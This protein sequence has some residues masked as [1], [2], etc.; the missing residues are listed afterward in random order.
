MLRE[1]LESLARLEGIIMLGIVEPDYP[2]D[3][4]RLRNWLERG[5]NADMHFLTRYLDLR[6][7]PVRLLPNAKS[8][9]VFALPYNAFDGIGPSVAGY[10][11]YPDYHQ[12]FRK[13][14]ERLWTRFSLEPFRVLVDSAPILERALAKKTARGFVGKN[15]CFIHP[16]Y[17]SFFLLGEILT[18]RKLPFDSPGPPTG[19]LRTESGGCGPCTACQVSC[20]TGALNHDFEMDSR[21]CLAYWTIEN[22]GPIPL[23]Y[24]PPMAKYWFGCDICQKVCPFNTSASRMNPTSDFLPQ[25]VPELFDVAVMNDSF[26]Q[27]HF[28]GTPLTRAKRSGL[29]RNAIIAMTVTDHPRLTQAI[30]AAH[31]DPQYPL[32]E[33]VAQIALFEFPTDPCV[34]NHSANPKSGTPNRRKEPVVQ[35]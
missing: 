17:G 30:E 6:T 19:N 12:V 21:K 7:R 5:L 2:E 14:L 13:K 16:E 32:L 26:Y 10:A 8:V 29:R 35:P 25:P 28:G 31:R 20:P 33:T 22:H 15:T 23:E 34:N 27:K 3:A 18:T 24:W 4:E 9:V 1:K 11:Q